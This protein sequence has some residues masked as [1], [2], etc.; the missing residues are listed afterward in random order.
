MAVAGLSLKDFVAQELDLLRL[1]AADFGGA[2]P[3][4]AHELALSGGRSSDPHVE[5]MLQS[6]A[7]LAGQ[8]RYQ[9]D[10]DRSL[11]P[12]GLLETLHPHL[13][14]SLPATGVVQVDVKLEGKNFGVGALLERGRQLYSDVQLERKR[15]ARCRFRTCFDTELWPLEVTDTSMVPT[16]YYDFLAAQTQ[17]G[18]VLRVK[19]TATG[20]LDMAHFP[21]E[22][23]RFHISPESRPAYRV[24][25]WLFAQLKGIMLLV[26]GQPPRRLPAESVRWLG[27]DEAEAALPARPLSQPAYRLLQ[28]YFAFPEKFL[29]FDLH[30]LDLSQAHDKIEIL[31]LLDAAAGADPNLKGSLLLNCVPVINLYDQ[32][33]EPV[34]L[35]QRRYEYRL[36]GDRANRRYCEVYE[37][38]RLYAVGADGQAKPLHSP[39]TQAAFGADPQQ[40]GYALRVAPAEPDHLAGTETYVQLIDPKL[41]PAV[42]PDEVL[43]GLALCT[44]R[45]LANS[46]R[47]D[48]V[49]KLEGPGPAKQIWMVGAPNPHRPP[50]LDSDCSWSLVS[51]LSLNYLPLSRGGQMLDVFKEMLKLHLNRQDEVKARQVHSLTGLECRS[52][53]RFIG[54]EHWRGYARGTTVHLHVDE[55]AFGQGSPLLMS[56]VLHRFF[57]LFSHV[58][59]FVELV[60][61]CQGRSGVWNRW[62]PL[63]GTQ[64]LL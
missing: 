17:V 1:D 4:L 32:P 46:M 2:Y 5:L 27:M 39:L 23:L 51:L 21:L 3:A 13:V 6:F 19:V 61:T 53:E 48:D 52:T 29:F 26:P 10:Q 64:E 20:G 50:L 44:N 30:G 60:L 43:G 55:A 11:V 42:V 63:A 59:H 8:L 56:A 34:R 41:N 7:Y 18:A 28:E 25:E 36:E 22:H 45:D 31:F 12:L 40:R 14:R 54:S 38:E 49:L 9:Q 47:K 57:A 62:P 24:Y 35:D 58:N 37:V 15:H 33:L 16:N